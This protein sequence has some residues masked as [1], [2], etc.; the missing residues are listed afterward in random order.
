MTISPALR[1][2]LGVASLLACAL[3]VSDLFF[4][5]F[6]NPHA[7]VRAQHAVVAEVATAHVVQ[8]LAANDYRLIEEGLS[9]VRER[10]PDILSI[11]VRNRAGDLIAAS[12][13]TLP[14][15]PADILR[16][17]IQSAE[18]EWG[19]T[20]F[21]FEPMPQ[22]G[23]SAWLQDRRLWLMLGLG[24]GFLS[25]IYFYLRRALLYLDPMSVVP[26]RLRTAFDSLTEGIALLDPKHR[27]VLGNKALREMS[28]APDNK[29]LGRRLE[30]AAQL[31]IKGHSSTLPW[32]RVIATGQPVRGVRVYV[33]SGEN[34]K[35]G[36][37]NCAPIID[38]L[39]KVR[40]CLVTVSDVTAIERSN[41]QLRTALTEV[42]LAHRQIETQN[43]ELK[44]L[45]MYDG[46]TSLMNRRAFFQEAAEIVT[47]QAGTGGSVAVLML[48]VDH[49]KSFNDRFGH[50]TGDVVL[51]RV[52]R[53]LA[54]TV[55][56]NDLAARYGGEE[57]CVLVENLETAAVMS[58]AE[59][60]RQA[61]EAGAALN[62]QGNVVP[63]TV[64]IGV[65]VA[66][67]A[68]VDLSEMVKAADTALY[69]SKHGGRNRVT[70]ADQQQL[71]LSR[72][73]DG[74]TRDATAVAL[75]HAASTA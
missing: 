61:V 16:V 34:R 42:E 41:E 68:G 40:G 51:Q 50:A 19:H 26:D 12:G 5:L 15:L 45:A 63:V 67:P 37:L 35:T 60:I 20:E 23:G 69:A 75:P 65:C 70:L 14:A 1:L 24:A 72:K 36:S 10:A 18:G 4:G 71:V 43:K 48:D 74:A 17:P 25:M 13:H 59:R 9:A 66:A 2:S 32:Q 54:E 7:G 27:V 57:F 28:N 33:G 31:E 64:S 52:A 38:G 53:C 8:Q 62:T 58:L 56:F 29:L 30:E 55:R 46:L 44:R 6:S 73:L 22:E 49:F 39:G 47:R 21:V 11:T 3:V